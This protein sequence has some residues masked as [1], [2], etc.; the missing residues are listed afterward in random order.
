[1]VKLF[2]LTQTKMKIFQFNQDTTVDNDLHPV[3]T[4]G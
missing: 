2:P 4:E 3:C 1:M